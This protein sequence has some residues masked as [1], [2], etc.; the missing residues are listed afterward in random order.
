MADSNQ[1]LI[2]FCGRRGDILETDSDTMMAAKKYDGTGKF[3]QAAEIES[4]TAI[5]IESGE[6]KLFSIYCIYCS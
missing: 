2:I 3:I 6:F 4:W 5:H 1:D